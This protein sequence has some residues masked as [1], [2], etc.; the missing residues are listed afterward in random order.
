MSKKKRLIWLLFPSYLV[1]TIVSLIAASWYAS[2]SMRRFYLAQTRQ[3]LEARAVT[4]RRE[5][6]RLLS[7]GDRRGIDRLCKS[8]GPATATRF[9]LIAPDGTVFGDSEEDPLRMN[10]H[11]GRPEVRPALVGERGSAIRFSST[12]RR[13]MMYVAIPLRDDNQVVGALRT[14]ISISSIDETLTAI[15][16]HIAVGGFLVALGAAV[17]SL[18]VTRRISRPIE[19][20]TDGAQRFADGDLNHRLPPQDSE[21]MTGLA[22]ALNRMANEID[23]RM[24]EIVEQRRNVDAVLASM[25]EG[26]VAIDTEERVIN[27]NQAAAAMLKRP[28]DRVKGRLLREVVRNTELHRLVQKALET[29][30]AVEADIV[31][32]QLDERILHTQATRLSDD[33]ERGI[34][35]LIVL[36]DVTQLRRLERMRQDFAANVSHE[37]KTPLTAIKGFVETLQMDED[38]DPA[39]RRQFLA[40]IEKHVRRL[41]A[42]IED[43]LKLSR[44]EQVRSAEG[45]AVA[46]HT[47]ADVLRDAVSLCR[48]NAEAKSIMLNIDC[49]PELTAPMDP[50]LMV[51]ALTNLIDN[52]INYS[53]AGSRVDIAAAAQSDGGVRIDVRDTGIGIPKKHLPR[54]FERFYRVDQAR[55]RQQG[56]T[57]LG[58]SIVKHII[59]AH[60]GRV[61]VDSTPYKGSV[62]S[63]HLDTADTELEEEGNGDQPS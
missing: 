60:N 56:G 55:S 48:Q 45:I 33:R 21:E 24:R 9:T 49:Q 39:E 23:R 8:L 20:M 50:Q 40:I 30:Q 19:M 12:L 58:L 22:D 10:N 26:V 28:V 27:V 57:G 34:G 18:L 61:S 54:L 41:T 17:I 1:I 38:G 59:Q 3:D 4:A 51:Q 5:M 7:T 42:I 37:I 46:P 25:R 52:A 32:K 13:R 6:L 11:A 47:V 43:L 15:Q 31:F 63:L 29:G 44:L 35:M 62:F 53:D 14:S 16:T 2:V 36:S